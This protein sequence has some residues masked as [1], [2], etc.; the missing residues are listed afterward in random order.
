MVFVSKKKNLQQIVLTLN[1]GVMKEVSLQITIG[2]NL[3]AIIFL[4]S[5]TCNL[6]PEK[7][8]LASISSHRITNFIIS[9]KILLD[10]R[11]SERIFV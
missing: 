6:P 7:I 5:S 9:D 2:S 4:I 11:P 3:Q 8:L 1:N 10:I